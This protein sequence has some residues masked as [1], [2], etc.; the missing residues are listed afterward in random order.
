MRLKALDK[1][2]LVLNIVA[3]VPDPLEG[4]RAADLILPEL[5][6]HVL[7]MDVDDDQRVNDLL[8]DFSELPTN[9][10]DDITDLLEQDL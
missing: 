6:N 4:V 1:E 2:V 8:L 7:R 9:T 10:D 5:V 3:Q